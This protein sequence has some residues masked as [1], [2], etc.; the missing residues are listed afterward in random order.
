MWERFIDWSWLLSLMGSRLTWKTFGGL[1]SPWD[2]NPTPLQGAIFF[3]PFFSSLVGIT[4]T[5]PS[6]L[7]QLAASPRQKPCA[8]LVSW[9]LQL[10]PRGYL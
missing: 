6:A 2:E 3:L 5:S 8:L 1:H 10:G 4:L 7:L 9:F